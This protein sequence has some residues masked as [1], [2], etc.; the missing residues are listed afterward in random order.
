[1]RP[2]SA[3]RY[4][5]HAK[6]YGVEGVYAAARAE[7]L[8]AEAL[9]ELAAELRR[10]D[11]DAERSGE[12]PGDVETPSIEWSP[13]APIPHRNAPFTPDKIARSTDRNLGDP[14]DR[15]VRGG[16]TCEVCDTALERR[17]QGPAPRFCSDRCRKVAKRAEAKV[18]AAS[19]LFCAHCGAEFDGEAELYR[20]L[21]GKD[22][23]RG[24]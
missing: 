23:A 15:P 19:R 10:I 9:A 14:P 2:P 13:R 18:R 4:A 11:P 22:A 6:L 1:M 12:H 20:H 16:L 24:A 3:S 7:G 8:D 21:D 5:R 17:S